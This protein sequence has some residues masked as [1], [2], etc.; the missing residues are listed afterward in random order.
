MNCYEKLYHIKRYSDAVG[1][2]YGTED[3]GL[4]FY[5]L[6][7]MR[8]PQRVVELGTGLGIIAL[9]GGLA[10]EENGSGKLITIDNGSE[11]SHISQA[12]D[13]IGSFFHSDYAT[14]IQQ[15]IS[16]FELSATVH[17]EHAE[18]NE[19]KIFDGVDILFSDFSHGPR[20]IIMLL[21]NYL[22]RMSECSVMMF[23]S[24][25]TYYPSYQMLE[26]L[27]PMLNAGRIPE[28]LLEHAANPDSLRQR[29]QRTEFKLHHVVEAKPRSQN[30]TACLYLQPV[31]L[32]P[33]PRTTMRAL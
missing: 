13:R 7:K 31:D 26:Q 6:V 3:F 11:W 33:Y 20:D 24:A 28:A 30:S 5:S 16:T 10:L 19:V 4:Y 9:W 8:R 17:F 14:Y 1:S 23:D 15:L 2:I 21:S 32:I 25:S 18:I 29:V 12:R 27:V 22:E